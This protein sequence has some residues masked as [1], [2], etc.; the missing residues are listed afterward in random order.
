[1]R[2][3]KMPTRDVVEAAL[4][5]KGGNI[6]KAAA[7]LGVSRPTLYDWIWKLDL[8]RVAGLDSQERKE[9]RERQPLAPVEDVGVS[10]KPFPPERPILGAMETVAATEATEDVRLPHNVRLP[11]S[12][13]RKTQH[14]S[15]DR[16]ITTSDLVERA[17][18]SFLG[19]GGGER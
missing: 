13:W 11:E 19:M 1:M 6:T 4:R 8:S 5:S 12:V 10:V 16:G 15:I 14:E 17:L 18:R 7:V 9:S 3:A 2:P